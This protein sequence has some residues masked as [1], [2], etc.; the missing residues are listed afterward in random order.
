[1]EKAAVLCSNIHAN[2]ALAAENLR[3]N[4]F[5]ADNGA[6]IFPSISNPVFV[7]L[8]GGGRYREFLYANV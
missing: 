7:F 8:G 6:G 1:M 4:A 5:G 2:T 3:S